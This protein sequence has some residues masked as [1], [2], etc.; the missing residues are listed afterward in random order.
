VAKNISGATWLR[1]NS[2]GGF[3]S[4][5]NAGVNRTSSALVHGAL[6][7]VIGA[8]LGTRP[9][10]NYYNFTWRGVRHMHFGWCDFSAYTGNLSAAPTA[11]TSRGWAQFFQA[12]LYPNANSLGPATAPTGNTKV[13]S[14][15][16]DANGFYPQAGGV[17]QS[18]VFFTIGQ[19]G[20]SNA[21]NTG[22]CLL[23]GVPSGFVYA[24]EY[25]SCKYMHTGLSNFPDAKIWR[26]GWDFTASLPGSVYG[27]S[28]ISMPNASAATSPANGV[29]ISVNTK[30]NSGSY[31]P[32]YYGRTSAPVVGNQWNRHEHRL[33]T[34]LLRRINNAAVTSWT[35]GGQAGGVAP[36]ADG[37]IQLVFPGSSNPVVCP[38][39]LY[40]G[41]TDW[42]TMYGAQGAN[43]P[44]ATVT[45]NFADIYHD[46]TWARVEITDGVHSEP[47]IITRWT[48]TAID[49]L[50]NRGE[51]KSGAATLNVYDATDSIIWS[52]L[53]QLA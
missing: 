8:N 49:Y 20:Y 4:T 13:S 26:T 3:N 32:L 53:V 14:T 6:S 44:D 17:S 15:A 52:Q 50:H 51:L 27:Q 25:M 38:S 28:W 35:V 24:Q 48:P 41:G 42:G 10:F 43:F 18:G 40:A 31:N 9:D 21:W 29:M 30:G 5:S 33:D 2:S 46:F 7:T 39:G 1:V 22:L 19:V 36:R 23:R 34:H 47:Q 37:A 11:Y 16:L 12:G 45:H